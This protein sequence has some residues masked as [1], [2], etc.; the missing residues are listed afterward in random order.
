MSEIKLSDLPFGSLNNLQDGNSGDSGDRRRTNPTTALRLA[1]ESA[2]SKDTL[3]NITEFNG[4]IVSYRPVAYASYKNRTA[5]FEQFVYSTTPAEGEEVV[6]K[7]YP[8]TYAYKVYIPE[9]EPRPAPKTFN[10][11]VLITYPDVYSDVEGTDN[12]PLE[13]GLLVSVKYEDADNLFNPR[14]V[15]KVGGPIQIQ[16]VASAELNKSFRKG[17]PKTVGGTSGAQARAASLP[18]FEGETPNA[19]ELRKVLRDLGYKEKGNEISNG[20]DLES[21]ILYYGIDVFRKIRETYPNIEVT[22][23]GGNDKYHKVLNYESRHRSGKALDFTISP[24]TESGILG[25]VRILQGYSAGDSNFRFLNEYDDP[26]RAATGDHFHISYR[27][28]GG[29]E[30]SANQKEASRLAAAGTIETFTAEIL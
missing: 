7:D 3:N 12:L 6:K 22:V 13:L 21:G 19:E 20:G 28:T 17:I 27:S 10:D 29:S 5:M 9:L 30:G 4:V 18:D 25:I 15:R 16:N 26:T 8:M 14:I 2:Y 24:S 11:P 1:V 23:T